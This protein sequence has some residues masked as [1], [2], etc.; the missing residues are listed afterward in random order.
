MAEGVL[1]FHLW[2]STAQQPYHWTLTSTGNGEIIC[3]SENYASKADAKHSMGLVHAHGGDAK[4]VDHT[5]ED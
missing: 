4:Y 1:Q 2:K 3:T 5:G